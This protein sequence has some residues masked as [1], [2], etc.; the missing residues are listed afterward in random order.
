MSQLATLNGKL[1]RINPANNHIEI[2]STGAMIWNP[3]FTG[4]TYGIFHALVAH[5]GELLAAT[6]RGV[7]A[8]SN[9]GRTWIM[10]FSGSSYGTFRDLIDSGTELMAQ[11]D[12]GLYASRDGGRMWLPRR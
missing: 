9:E 8:S 2:S 3:V 10:R 11:T 7:Y 12:R 6:D 1:I 4:N 5:K